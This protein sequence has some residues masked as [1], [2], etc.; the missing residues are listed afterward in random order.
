MRILLLFLS[1]FIFQTFIYAQD[2]DVLNTQANN[3]NPILQINGFGAKKNPISFINLINFAPYNILLEYARIN[4]IE[5]YPSDTESDLRARII[6]K[7]VNVKVEKLSEDDI[8]NKV[9]RENISRGGGR[10]ELISADFVERY[11]IKE[12]NEEIISLYGNVALRMYDYNLHAERVV[13][14]L[15]S[16][17][18]FAD[19]NLTVI[20]DD[21]KLVGSWFMLNR[22]TKRGLL[23]KGTTQFQVFSVEG[24]VIKF[25][26]ERFFGEKSHVSFSRLTP[27]AHDF[28]ASRV[29]VWDNRN[30]MIF[31]SIYR[32]GIQPVFYFPLFMQNYL[33]TGIISAFGQSLREGVY[34]Q[35]YKLLNLY[36][37]DH[38]I[39]FDYYQILGFLVGDEIR[40]SSQYNNLSLD[41]MFAL[42][43]QYYLLDSYIASRLG[44]GTKYVNYF[45]DGLSGKFVPRYRFAY[46]HTIVLHDKDNIRSSLSGAL[47][48]TSDLYF[49]SDYYNQRPNFDIL[50]FFTSL[51]GNIQDIG[52]S[53]PESSIRN[54]IAINNNFYGVNF[55]VSAAWDLT[56][57]RNLSAD[58]NTNFDYYK[59]KPSKLTLPSLNMSYS[60]TFGKET[61]YFFPNV[62]IQYS[63]R[64][65][66]S[67]TIDYKTSEG[68]RFADNPNLK[69]QLNEKLADRHNLGLYGDLARSFTNMFT[70]FTPRVNMEYNYQS[71]LNPTAED[72]VY[73][74]NNTYF[75]M[76]GTMNMSMYL[77]NSILPDYFTHYFE[78]ILRWDNTYSI[79]YRFRD[80]YLNTDEYGGFN[81]NRF[82]TSFRLGG[83]GYSLFYIPDVNLTMEGFIGTGY[84]LRPRYDLE[85]KSYVFYHQSN[86]FLTTEAGSSAR[87]FYDRSYVSYE[88]RRNLLSTNFTANRLNTYIH[89]PIPLGKLTDL[90]LKSLKRD[91]FFDGIINDFQAYMGFSYVHDFINYRYNRMSFT[92]G[93]ELQIENVWKFR[94]STT[95]EN[96]RAYRYIKK[97]A[98]KENESWV[99]PFWDI[100]NSFDFANSQKRIDSLFKLSA[101]ETS[102]WHDLDGWQIQATFAVKPSVL[103]SDLT[104]G[105]VKGNYWDKEFW[106]EFTLVDFPGVGL[107]RKEFNLNTSITEL[108]DSKTK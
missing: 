97:Y 31:N 17:E 24:N 54:S 98:E 5:T 26:D 6:E 67:H 9:F 65:N 70:T 46:D 72:L 19:G 80:R 49:K 69:G 58:N 13:Y 20:N 27:V 103:P 79:G 101:I 96:G 42:G 35:N 100:I 89:I 73:D 36:G 64:G 86:R 95:S 34:V 48:L 76:G 1:M 25:N 77:P 57:V 81:D 90:I 87:L 99:N 56:A 74:R 29:Y 28:L 30:I 38:K 2:T 10:I 45:G 18:V 52:N 4:D 105:S 92:F 44:F 75:G 15:K 32:V 43:R 104:T 78:P 7:Q 60:D 3:D 62:N 59:S 66:Y 102:V 51:T 91:S 50:S 61:S 11:T 106:I 53:Y 40:Y 14:S 55:D 68:I 93:I 22:E 82:N 108:R 39:R 85:T 63:L 107:P 84:D 71:S 12:A 83:T 23:F 37:V 88:I 16:G 47:T 33:G 8:V 41:A 21:N 94:L